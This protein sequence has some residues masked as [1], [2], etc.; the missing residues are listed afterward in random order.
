MKRTDNMDGAYILTADTGM[1]LAILD[2]SGGVIARA[3]EVVIPLA[4]TLNVWTEVAEE[5]PESADRDP[6]KEAR[7]AVLKAELAK[8]ENN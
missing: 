7:I 2:E 8:L 3:K 1:D 6:E 5:I 4:G